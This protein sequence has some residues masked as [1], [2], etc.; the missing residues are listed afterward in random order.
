MAEVVPADFWQVL[1][2]ETLFSR[3][4][5]AQ[6]FQDDRLVKPDTIDIHSRGFDAKSQ[7]L[8]TSGQTNTGDPDLRPN[9]DVRVVGRDRTCHVDAVGFQVN[10]SFAEGGGNP[11]RDF[12][13]AGPL[14]I[15]AVLQPIA[16]R[17]VAHTTAATPGSLRAYS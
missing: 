9:A 16:R 4:P 6:I 12:I 1:I 7:M 13:R 8:F 5:A 2:Q 10:H 3:F 14:N 17:Q 11:K 15:Y